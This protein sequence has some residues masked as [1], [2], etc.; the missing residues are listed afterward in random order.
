MWG[1]DQTVVDVARVS[2]NKK[3]D[4]YTE[5]ENNKLIAFLARNGHWSP[6]AH[7]QMRFRIE[8]PIYVERQVI[9][10]EEGR[11]YNSISGRYVDF[12]DTYTLIDQFRYQSTDSKQG[13][14]GN[15]SPEDNEKALQIQSHVIETCRKAYQDL[16]ELNVS[17]EQSRSILPLALNT[18][19]IYTCSLYTLIRLCNQR[20]APD[21]QK[22]TGDV[23][24]EMLRLVKETN[25]FKE[26]LKNFGY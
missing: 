10:T 11:E 4:N 6:F 9:K 15:L 18:S 16:M 20:L 26:S 25:L 19:Q 13:S 1:S 17:K 14:A 23:I 21:A 8:M 22:E 12:S 2:Y 5:K 24:S 7:A 3:A